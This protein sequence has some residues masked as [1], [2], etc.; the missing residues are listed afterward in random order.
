MIYIATER[1]MR[2]WTG[3]IY[4]FYHPIPD[5]ESVNDTKTGK[6][7]RAH[8]FSC[9][10]RGCK[11][12]VR[13]YLDT[14]DRSST[15]NLMRH[16]VSCWGTDAVKAAQGHGT[17]KAARDAVTTPS[18]RD[19]D[20]ALAFERK[21][22]GKIMY[23]TRQHTKTKVSFQ[24][25]AIVE[26]DGFKGLMKTGRPE[27]YL[28]SQATVSRDVKRVFLRSRKRIAKFLQEYDGDLNFQ[29]DN[30]TSPNHKAYMGTT[31]TLEHRGEMLTFVL[32]M[33]EV[34]K[35]LVSPRNHLKHN[36]TR[37]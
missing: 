30:W 35:V 13:R 8:T 29:T 22:K 3:P 1:M 27:I 19:G 16:A 36:L 15:S 31:V 23:S 34:A 5:I 28:P 11:H 2:K 6:T 21:G 33:V 32:D 20:I 4:A 12:K 24:P 14:G 7:R 25:F 10:N 9:Y 37:F 18:K 26:D 17:A